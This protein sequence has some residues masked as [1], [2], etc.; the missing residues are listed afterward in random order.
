MYWPPGFKTPIPVTIKGNHF[1]IDVPLS[2]RSQP[3]MYEVSIWA[4]QPG[5]NDF[6]IVGLRTMR[7]E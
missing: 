6:M 7:V 4:K 3:G 1:A 2:D 5:S